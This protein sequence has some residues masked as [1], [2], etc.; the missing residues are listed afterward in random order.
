MLKA[1]HYF[2]KNEKEAGI[3]KLNE[4]T[5]LEIL[6]P[7]SIK[8]NYSL[9]DPALLQIYEDRSNRILWLLGDVS[10]EQ[11]YDWVDFIF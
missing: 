2:A 6:L 3:T 1:N 9:P 8:E 5:G 7:Q 4:G 11:G 10:E